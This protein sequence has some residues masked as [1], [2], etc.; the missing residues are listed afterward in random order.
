[1]SREKLHAS[2]FFS[3]A[4]K[5]ATEITGLKQ[6]E[7]AE[8]LSVKPSVVSVYASGKKEPGMNMVMAVAEA[9]GYDI[10]DFLALGRGDPPPAHQEQADPLGM[11]EEVKAQNRTIRQLLAENGELRAQVEALKQVSVA[12]DAETEGP[13]AALGA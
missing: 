8:R 4:Y 2:E 7:I 3:E 1:M 9:F 11:W 13:G 12:Q 6:R 5:R 10:V